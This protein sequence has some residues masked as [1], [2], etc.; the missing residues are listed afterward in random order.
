[1]DDHSW[2]L[3]REDELGNLV[4]V[5]D[6]SD[7]RERRRR[8]LSVAKSARVRRGLIRF[9]TV[10]I[11]LSR[12]SSMTDMR[13][14]RAAV[15]SGI[16]QRFIRVYFDEN[17]LSQLAITVMRDGIA[18]SVTQ[19][20]SS[21]ELHIEKLKANIDTSGDASL[22]NGLETALETLSGVPPYGHKEILVLFAALAT[23][24]P[25]SISDTIAAARKARVR[26]SVVGLAAEVYICR[27][28]SQKT[29]GRYGVALDEHHLEELVLS[30]A[31]PPPAPPGQLQGGVS[32]VKM[33]F[34]SRASDAPGSAAFVGVDAKLMAGAYCCP[35]C[36]SRMAT[37]PAQCHVC[38]LTLVSSPHLARSYHHLFPIRPF[39]DLAADDPTKNNITQCYG[40]CFKLE[41]RQ[42]HLVQCPECMNIFCIDCD[43]FIHD[44]LHNC[45]GCEAQ[46]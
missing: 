26:V 36:K 41:K 9:L 34:P 24:D 15:M 2:E 39:T 27:E 22:Q 13:P 14:M 28:I 16:V 19:L 43:L 21:P 46:Q 25:G 35:R 31:T 10:I 12:A 45:P 11:D 5:D 44:T 32:L 4:A 8:A 42:E 33:G 18:E 17:P 23:C 20:S 40:C 38:G 7:A 37:L 1:M 6:S 30:H 29:G 3:L